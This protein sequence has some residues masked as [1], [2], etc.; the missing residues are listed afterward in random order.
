MAD[1]KWRGGAVAV[2]QVQNF[3]IDGTWEVGDLIRVTIGAKIY[4]YAVTS[5]TIATFL[6][7]FV[8]A[9][10]ALDS[11]DYP[12]FAEITASSSSPTL[13][14]TADTAGV[15]FTVTLTPL[16]SDGSAAD[17]QTIDG[18]GT[19]GT[20]TTAT[21]SAGPNDWS[22]AANWSTGAVPVNSDNVYLENNDDDIKYGLAQSAVTVT[23]LE[24]R[25]SF[26]GTIGLPKVNED[27][28]EYPEY[29]ADTL[30]ISATTCNIGNG[31]GNGSGRLKLNFG[32]VQTTLNVYA[33][34]SGLDDDQAALQW[35]GTHASNAVNIYRGEVDVAGYPAETATI[36]TLRVGFESGQE[37]DAQVRL[38][39]GTTLTTITQTGGELEINSAATTIT[40]HGGSLTVRGTGAI[41][42]LT[43]NDGTVTHLSSGTVTTYTG[44][45]GSTLDCSPALIAK[46][47]TTT[48]IHAGATVLDPQA[49]V[50]WTNGIV[51][52]RCRIQDVSL[53]L[54]FN[55]TLTPS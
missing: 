2:A 4:D 14:F 55:R 41:T 9:F 54:G 42:T 26:T 13:T 52:S 22:T 39:S 34:G 38:A 17:A 16:E 35:K 1:V 44:G 18:S 43:N 8:T 10:N 29:R 50:T 46:T 33:T 47:F 15:P 23:L 19:A 53:D 40:R 49:L 5:T 27:A 6:P 36:A 32:S 24:I 21:A 48:T 25:A 3:T 7:L 28:T 37:S 30:A 12:E 11:D 31:P 51:L 20:G 45:P